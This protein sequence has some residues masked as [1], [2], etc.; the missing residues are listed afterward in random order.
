MKTYAWDAVKLSAAY[1]VPELI[2]LREQVE[3]QH[4][5][6]NGINLYDKAGQRKL[7]AIGYAIYYHQKGAA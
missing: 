5:A 3:K 1:T 6:Q 2:Q 4:H 7:A